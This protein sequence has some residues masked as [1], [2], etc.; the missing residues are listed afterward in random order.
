MKD[1]M[2]AAYI[3]IELVIVAGIVLVFGLFAINKF[4]KQGQTAASDSNSAIEKAL[5]Q[6]KATPA[7]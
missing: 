1:L 7:N 3:S 6:A 5:S 2:K 4:V